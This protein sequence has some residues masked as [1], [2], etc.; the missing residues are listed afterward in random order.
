MEIYTLVKAGIKNRK[1]I[2]I[3]FMLLTM[4]IVISVITMFGVRKNYELAQRKAFEVEDNGVILAVVNEDNYSEEFMDKIEAQDTVDHVEVHDVLVGV[5]CQIGEEKDGNGY[6][7]IKQQNTIPIFN[8]DCTELIMPS[9]PE[10]KNHS[11]NKGEIYLPYGLTNKLKA[12]VGSKLEMDFLNSHE[13]F[14]VKGFVQEAY[15]G[16]SIIGYKIVYLSDEDFDDLYNSNKE[17]IVDP[18]TDGWV[19]C[20]IVFVYPSDKAPK[21]SDVFLRDLSLK[22]KLNDMAR[23]TLTRETSEHYT[24]LFIDIILAVITGFAI[25]LFVIFLIVAGHNVST[26]L[27]IEYRNLGILKSLGFPDK[28]IQLIYVCQYLIVELI[29]TLLGV[30]ISIPCERVMSKMFFKLTALLPEKKLPIPES[31]FFMVLLFAVTIVYVYVFTRKVSKTSPVKAIT[32]GRED[33]YFDSS[34]NA[35]VKKGCMAFWLGL[36]QITSAPK[37]YISIVIV[38]VLLIFTIITTE[39]MS[40]YIQSRNALISMGEPFTDIEFGFNVAEPGCKV[41][42]I[43]KIIKKYSDIEGRQYK[44]H[45]YTSVNGES[46]M[47]F[48]KGYPDELSSVYKGREIKYDNEVVIT[49]QVSKLL[50][51]KI[52]D[53]LTIG[54]Y[55]QSA[56]Y[57][58][59]GIFQTMNDTGKAVAITLD[60]F[61][62]LKGDSADPSTIDQLGM[63]GVVLKDPSRGPEIEKEIREKYGDVL[64]V[65]YNDFDNKEGF[66][67]NDF[68]LAA[69]GSKL[70]IYI[71]S[72]AFAIVTIIMVCSKAFIQERTDLGIYRATGFSVGRVRRSFATRFMIISLLSSVIAVILGRL[73]SAKLLESVFSLFGIGHIEMYYGPMFFIKPIV[74]FA[75]CYLV[76]GYLASRKVKKLS[77]REL[78]TE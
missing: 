66:M 20:K 17:S 37:R 61:N 41:S 30:I 28:K 70:L 76:F 14:T 71:L 25:L 45:I 38:T 23:A 49:E 40:G 2:M 33:Y 29:G 8:D 59:V 16:S 54:R 42:D 26:E 48:V 5:N 77:A 44:S 69:E 63:Y 4:L 50:D 67:V 58:V 10:Y 3:G 18:V 34:I 56:K 72:F 64:E 32:N 1:G 9:S 7:I 39:L 31:L 19:I 78:I 62:R 22:T 6:F 47:T 24:G 74:I 60:G 36:R 35:P 73:Y 53:K 46:L 65:E 13:T 11:L 12:E 55:E 57:M 21:S 75:L 15:M 27:E 43:E 68:Y 52:G 51:V